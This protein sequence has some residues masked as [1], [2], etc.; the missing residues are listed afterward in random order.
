VSMPTARSEMTVRQKWHKE[1]RAV[2]I[3]R[4]T[5]KKP[6]L[7]YQHAW[8]NTMANNARERSACACVKEGQGATA[9]WGLFKRG[10]DQPPSS[11]INVLHS[12]TKSC[13][14]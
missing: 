9:G 3:N 12:A 11:L 13:V 5:P 6:R 1:K 7:E 10:A 14:T 2:A 8:C 4:H